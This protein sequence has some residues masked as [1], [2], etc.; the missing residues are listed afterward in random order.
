MSKPWVILM[1]F[2]INKAF[3]VMS[4]DHSLEGGTG[5]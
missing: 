2:Y 1:I 4:G 3:D 5:K